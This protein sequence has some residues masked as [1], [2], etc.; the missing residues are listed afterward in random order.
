MNTK[1]A[2][3]IKGTPA[4]FPSAGNAHR[5]VSLGFERAT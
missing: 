1:Y 3:G 4:T 5:D 2:K